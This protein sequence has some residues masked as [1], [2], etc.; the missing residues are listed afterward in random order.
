MVV[1]PVIISTY[2]IPPEQ[3]DLTEHVQTVPSFKNETDKIIYEYICVNGFITT[4]EILQITKIST[5]QGA[6][7]AINRLLKMD[8]I[9]KERKGRRFVYRLKS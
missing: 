8:L 1:G 3:L 2:Q 7:L 4:P 9:R 5:I 6:N